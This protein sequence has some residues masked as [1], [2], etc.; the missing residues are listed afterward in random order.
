MGR[1]ANEANRVAYSVGALGLLVHWGG[2]SGPGSQELDS[3]LGDAM[4]IVKLAAVAMAV[5]I[6]TSQAFGQSHEP[7]WR[8]AGYTGKDVILYSV[9]DIVREPAGRVRVWSEELNFNASGQAANR[10]AN[11]RNSQFLDAVAGR[12]AR[13][14]EPPFMLAGISDPCKASADKHCLANYAMNIAMTEEAANERLVRTE[15][16]S[17][18]ELD[19]TNKRARTLQAITYD[20]GGSPHFWSSAPHWIY[21]PPQSNL[22]SLLTIVCNPAV[23]AADNTPLKLRTRARKSTKKGRPN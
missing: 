6:G 15:D 8:V 17:L 16:L 5:T 10:A 14:Y 9:P 4:D 11:K 1:R 2:I 21:A 13:Y 12:V 20:K 22:A 3:R 7:D 18:Y 19:C 23:A